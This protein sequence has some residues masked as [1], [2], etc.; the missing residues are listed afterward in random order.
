MRPNA[1]RW[2]VLK[3]I[4]C[5]GKFKRPIPLTVVGIL[6]FLALVVG[7]Q[8][9]EVI[10]NETIKKVLGQT[11]AFRK[12]HS[13]MS[14]NE[15]RLQSF[16][17]AFLTGDLASIKTLAPEIAVSLGDVTSFL[18]KDNPESQTE[19]WQTIAEVSNQAKEIEKSANQED[20]IGTYNHYAQLIFQCVKC[21]QAVRSWGQ[22]PVPKPKEPE[23]ESK[24]KPAPAPLREATK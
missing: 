15:N 23:T 20:L 8:A 6:C 14:K 5:L 3:Q 10:T 17:N 4:Q 19:G 9:N 13:V 11:I 21:H 7:I 24:D 22:F 18:P 16:L 1:K 12:S 2:N